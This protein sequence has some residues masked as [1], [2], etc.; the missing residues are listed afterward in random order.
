M[1]NPF[2][3]PPPGLLGQIASYVY[4]QAPR[5]VVEIA[6]AAAIALMSAVCGRSYNVSG[7]G[8]NTYLL[9]LARTGT[10]KEA[11]ASG[12]DRL[13]TAVTRGVPAAAEFIGPAEISSPQAL[14]KYMANT[15]CS[16]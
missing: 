14:T 9:V 2:A 10:G 13:I 7:T 4:D 11:M 16:F 15:S 1:T 12:I 6:V 3:M 5:P 8:I